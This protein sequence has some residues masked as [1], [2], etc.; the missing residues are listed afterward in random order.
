MRRTGFNELRK[1]QQYSVRFHLIMLFYHGKDD[2]FSQSV[3]CNFCRISFLNISFH[4]PI[5]H[6]TVFWFV[7]H[8]HKCV[9][10]FSFIHWRI[11][12]EDMIHNITFIIEYYSQVSCI[13][14]QYFHMP[15]LGTYNIA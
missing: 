7:F 1:L 10:Q 14:E 11:R 3:L 13:Y 9:L 6:R 8:V 4:L 15:L 12:L 2:I 5:L